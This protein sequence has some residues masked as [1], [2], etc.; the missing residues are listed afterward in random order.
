MKKFIPFL[1]GLMIFPAVAL[2][3]SSPTVDPPP[4]TMNAD[5]YLL[6]IHT[7]TGAK[8]YVLGGPAN[9]PPVVDGAGTDEADGYVEVLVGLGQNQANAF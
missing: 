5:T 1:I 4:A 3:I 8:V 2:A 6:K 9:I 7:E